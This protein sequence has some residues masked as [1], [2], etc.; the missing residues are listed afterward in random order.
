MS[1]PTQRESGLTRD[2]LQERIAALMKRAEAGDPTC[3]KDIGILLNTAPGLVENNGSPARK[4]ALAL[5]ENWTENLL[6]RESLRRKLAEVRADLEGPNPTP[7]ERLLAE[8]AALCWFLV[9][10]YEW[11]NEETLNMTFA[12]ARHQQRL[13]DSAHKRFLSAVKTLATVRRLQVPALL[14]NI[15]RRQ[16][17]LGGAQAEAVAVAPSRPPLEPPG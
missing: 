13:I 3:E 4:L 12:Q 5:V 8:R 15:D 10:K 17:H 2:E 16:V 6:I 1:Q 9:Y 11:T 14:V 7:L